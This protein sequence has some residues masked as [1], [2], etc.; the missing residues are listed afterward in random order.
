M[1]LVATEHICQPVMLGGRKV[2][3]LLSLEQCQ[4][5]LTYGVCFSVLLLI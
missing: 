5:F 2:E 1:L 3:T 4:C